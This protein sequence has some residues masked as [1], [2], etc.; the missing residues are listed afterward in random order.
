MKKDTN[1]HFAKL[2]ITGFILVCMGLSQLNCGSDAG[3]G[4]TETGN[5]NS[6]TNNTS[7]SGDAA[8][9]GDSDDGDAT[10]EPTSD[11]DLN[12]SVSL[13]DPFIETLAQGYADLDFEAPYLL[14][15]NTAD[16][17]TF[18]IEFFGDELNPAPE[19]DFSTQIVAVAILGERPTSG[20]GITFTDQRIE[21]GVMIL[22]VTIIKPAS[23]CTVTET[24][25]NPYHIV[26]IPTSGQDIEI[27]TFTVENNCE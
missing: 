10:V 2:I 22:S 21:D 20:Y 9:E 3:C 15:N 23:S 8:A 18:W 1:M 6:C 11:N 25:V 5:P 19:V 27:E 26:S 24:P 12:A 17:E 14:Y 4:G 16:F 7:S 13:S